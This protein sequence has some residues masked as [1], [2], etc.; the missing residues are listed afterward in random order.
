[1]LHSEFMLSQRPNV[2]NARA[3]KDW[4]KELPLTDARA[5]HH[6]IETLLAEFEENGLAARDRLEILETIRPHRIE[7]DAQYAQR[8]AGKALPL[9]APERTAYGHA[10]SLWHKLEEAYWYCARAAAAGEPDLRPHLT[11]CL[12]RAAD[13]AGERLKGALRAG[14]ALDGTIQAALARYA[15]FAREQGVLTTSAP[16]S[17]HPKRIVSV[18]SVQNRALLISL[19]GGTVTGRERESAF[20]LATQ[21]EAKVVA[22]WLP[23]GLTR[24][25]TR[26]D[27]PPSGDPSKQRIR[28]LHSGGQIYFVDVTALSRSLRKRVH[29]LGLGQGIDE[30]GLPASFPRSGA[31]RLLT[32]LHG[33]WCEE[34]YGRRHPRTAPPATPGVTHHVSVAPVAESF[35][36]MYCMLTG[37]PFMVNDDSDVTSRKRFDEMFVFQGAGHARRDRHVREAQRHVEQWRLVDHSAAGARLARSGAGA[38]FKPGNLVAFRGTARGYDTTGQLG[39]VRWCSEN[40]PGSAGARNGAV[41]EAGIEVLAH[42]PTG[43]AIRLTGVNVAGARNWTAA[44]RTESGAGAHLLVTPAGWYKP[45]RVV[46]MRDQ[47]DG[48]PVVTRWLLGPLKRRGADFELVEA[49]LTT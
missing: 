33:A 39:E 2:A 1:M 29:L 6:A 37:E 18:A 21:W 23:S 4:L 43:V 46:E 19:L 14:Q 49:S 28:I 47:R 40:A 11:L 10:S 36:A 3:A 25:L 16:D 7:T 42:A 22:T 35:D 44:F 24:A 20:E 34:E 48:K 30:M 9:G 45:G 12:V 8:Y 32:R 13:L 41:L 31:A 5:A 38:R 17:E 27:L 26:A 15:T